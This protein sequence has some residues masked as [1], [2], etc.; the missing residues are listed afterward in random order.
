[1]RM[2][3]REFFKRFK[4]KVSPSTAWI[5][6]R[7]YKYTGNVQD[8][9]KSRASLIYNDIRTLVKAL[10]I[11]PKVRVSIRRRLARAPK[12]TYYLLLLF[13]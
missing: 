11:E 12:R 4:R 9:K 7:K 5:I 10:E 1:M 13:L 2:V 3:A 8:Q 6:W